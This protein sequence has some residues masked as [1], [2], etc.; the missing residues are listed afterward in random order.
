M[1]HYSFTHGRKCNFPQVNKTYYLF[2]ITNNEPPTAFKE[3]KFVKLKKWYHSLKSTAQSLYQ[4]LWNCSYNKLFFA[5]FEQ[6]FETCNLIVHIRNWNKAEAKGANCFSILRPTF[7]TWMNTSSIKRYA[8]E[9]RLSELAVI[10][11]FL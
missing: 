5:L 9:P 4:I 3:H 11:I 10:H 2:S 1:I 7:R 6:V 8:V